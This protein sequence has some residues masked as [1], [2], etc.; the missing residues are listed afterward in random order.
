[1]TTQGISLSGAYYT[2]ESPTVAMLASLTLPIIL[3]AWAEGVCV[4]VCVGGGG[5][6]GGGGRGGV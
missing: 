5:G 6:G 3:K 4:C 2:Y 1:M